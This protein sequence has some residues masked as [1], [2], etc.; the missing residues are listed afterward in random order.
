MKKGRDRN[1]LRKREG[2]S[3]SVPVTEL[4]KSY[5]S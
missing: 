5:Y 2:I 4:T 3:L 1:F